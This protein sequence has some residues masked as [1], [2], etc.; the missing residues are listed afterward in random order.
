MCR[1]VATVLG[2]LS[3]TLMLL[4]PGALEGAPE[5]ARRPV[6]DEAAVQQAQQLVREVY[7]KEYEQ[8]KTS[9]AKT[10][11]GKRLLEQ[12]AKSQDDPAGHYVLL[13]IAREVAVQGADAETALE[14]AQR[15][16]AGYEVEGPTMKLGILEGV[17]R[18][19]KGSTQCKALARQAVLV[20]EEAVAEDD[21]KTA[22]HAAELGNDAARRGRDHALARQI[23]ERLEQLKEAEQRYAE[24]QE[25]RVV[26]QDN[27]ADP[28]ANLT[29]GRYLCLVKGDW[30]KG[31][32]ML[33]LGSDPALKALAVKELKSPDT[34]DAQVELG[35]GWWD[36]ARTKEGREKESWM[37]RAGT[38]YREA[39]AELP[40]GLVRV[41]LEKRLKQIAAI[42]RPMPAV[43]SAADVGI[44]NAD[45]IPVGE[46]R[47]FG[48]AGGPVN[49]VA[50]TPDGRS[51]LAVYK[52]GSVAMWEVAT[53]RELMRRKIDGMVFGVGISRDGRWAV[54]GCQDT[55]FHILDLDAR[56]D[57]RTVPTPGWALRAVFSADGRSIVG[58]SEI[59]AALRLWD[60]ESKREVRRYGSMAGVRGLGL[61]PDGNYVLAGYT[62]GAIHVFDFATGKEFRT[63]KGHTGGIAAVAFLPDGRRAV[64]ASADK[65][66]RLWDVPGAAE[67][68]RFEGHQDAVTGVAASADGR[69][70]LS[71]S[72]DE[73]LRLWSLDSGELLGHWKHE[74]GAGGVAFLPDQRFAVSAGA[75]GT[76]RLW[77]LPVPKQPGAPSRE[78]APSAPEPRGSSP[79]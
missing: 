39:Q 54:C 58:G 46:V 14:A 75:D 40:T 64:S 7:G 26:L 78:E 57:V 36:V 13:R 37:L 4:G 23:A 9:Q 1:R 73:T 29:V 79:R 21:F 55:H 17:D 31:I 68:R 74:G 45:S 8:A 60:I 62:S 16:I 34:T 67:L 66:V 43:S 27:P 12:A 53:G 70:A 65:T 38:W 32:P 56:K 63:L 28:E 18:R 49:A 5:T 3:G 47:R 25:A 30:D 71:C 19:A 72:K 22:L 61:S 69:Y 41:K 20:V 50:V 11:L 2:V 51:V 76:V 42:G 77:K 59:A 24:A 10:A 15:L 6:P 33:A 44:P 35:D 48:S 52:D